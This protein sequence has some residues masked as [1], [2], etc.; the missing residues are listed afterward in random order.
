MFVRLSDED[1][2]GR[3]DLI[4]LG[5]WM[6]QSAVGAT[7]LGDS[8]ARLD[9]GAVGVSDVLKGPAAQ[10]AVLV[11]TPSGDAAPSGRAQGH[12]RGR[13]GL[14]VGGGMPGAPG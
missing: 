1:L 12:R 11:A 4:V 5:E 9:L 3:S 6:G 2:I 14:G 7:A 13:R 8:A 10:T